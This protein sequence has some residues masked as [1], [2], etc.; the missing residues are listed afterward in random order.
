MK[1]DEITTKN[2]LLYQNDV[3]IPL[4]IADAIAR[5]RGYQYAEFD[6]AYGSGSSQE[7]RKG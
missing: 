4:P 7:G 6:H 1:A 2:G 5:E 3:Y